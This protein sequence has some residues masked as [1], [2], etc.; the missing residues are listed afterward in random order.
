MY[1]ALLV[2]AIRV[3]FRVL[4][5]AQHGAHI[6]FTLPEVPLPEA[7]A[8]IRLGGPVSAEGMLAAVYDGLRLATPAPLRRGGQHPRQPEAA[9][10]VDAGRAARDRGGRDRRAQRGPPAHR[11]R[12]ARARA[13]DDSAV[14]PAA[15]ST[16][17]AR[18]RCP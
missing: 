1:L 3:V 11:E 9:A 13:L 10:A 4:L 5:D 2:I 7:V 15:G 6:L 16:S 14:N 18:S 17:C 8:G 12:P